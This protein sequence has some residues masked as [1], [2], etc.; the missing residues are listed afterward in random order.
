MFEA[1]ARWST[2]VYRMTAA[3][4]TKVHALVVSLLQVGLQRLHKMFGAQV[5]FSVFD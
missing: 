5:I 4:I 3:V 2:D 1:V